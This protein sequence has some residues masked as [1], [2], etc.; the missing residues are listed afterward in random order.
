MK[1]V[2]PP[3]SVGRRARKAGLPIAAEAPIFSMPEGK[4]HL[5]F[6][7]PNLRLARP[8]ATGHFFTPRRLRCARSASLCGS[9]RG[10]LCAGTPALTPHP[11]RGQPQLRHSPPERRRL[12]T[13]Q[14]H[15]PTRCGGLPA[16][17][18]APP[19]L[20]CVRLALFLFWTP[21]QGGVVFK[22][23]IVARSRAVF[24]ALAR[25]L[26]RQAPSAPSFRS[27]LGAWCQHLSTRSSPRGSA[28]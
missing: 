5:W 24:V 23:V 28:D 12:L 17:S 1:T 18:F 26:S 7:L 16:S 19:A 3:V 14:V 9:L 11:K 6:V 8:A 15:V 2:H 4:L 20:R 13:H 10:D 27:C 25:T 21:A 22:R